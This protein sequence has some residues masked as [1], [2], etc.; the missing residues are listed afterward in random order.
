MPKLTPMAT[1]C[2]NAVVS[3]GVCNGFKRNLLA[4]FA[5]TLGYA[6]NH[7]C[8]AACVNVIKTFLLRRRKKI[9]CFSIKLFYG[10]IMPHRTKLECLP[11]SSTP[12]LV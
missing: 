6:C 4:Y 5:K 7:F 10:N 11:L 3:L 2:S 12:T 1:G 9:Q 8:A